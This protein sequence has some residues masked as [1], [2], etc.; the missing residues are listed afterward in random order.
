MSK[1][2]ALNSQDIIRALRKA[3]FEEHR[4]KGSHKIFKKGNLRVTVPIHSRGLKKGTVH[5]IIEQA[6]F[7]IEEFIEFL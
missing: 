1:L 7:T 6:G 2:P 3:G 5:G 4:Q